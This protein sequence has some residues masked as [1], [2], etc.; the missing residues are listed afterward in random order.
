MFIISQNKRGTVQNVGHAVDPETLGQ[1]LEAIINNLDE[2][3]YYSR[4]SR[5]EFERVTSEEGSA[6]V[7]GRYQ[8][9]KHENLIIVENYGSVGWDFTP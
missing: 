5:R 7:V 9:G 8:D 4:F 3:G 2:N 1:V 6:A